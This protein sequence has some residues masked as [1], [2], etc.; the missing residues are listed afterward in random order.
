MRLGSGPT[1]P[2]SLAGILFLLPQSLHPACPGPS[3]SCSR[4]TPPPTTPPLPRFACSAQ[5]VAPTALECRLSPAQVPSSLGHLATFFPDL[6]LA[7]WRRHGLQGTSGLLLS[8]PAARPLLLGRLASTR[9]L[10]QPPGVSLCLASTPSAKLPPPLVLVLPSRVSQTVG[11]TQ[12]GR[13]H[14]A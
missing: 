8:P 2:S 14:T 7:P 11:R 4:Q 3:Q 9:S 13:L 6:C 1:A 5:L 12:E 10:S